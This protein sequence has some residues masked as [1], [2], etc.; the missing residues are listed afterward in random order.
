MIIGVTGATGF[1]GRAVLRHAHERGHEVIAFTRKPDR[2]VDRAMETRFFSTDAPPNL[3]GCEAVVH[4]AGEPIAG[5]WTPA[6]R[7]RIME[8]RVQGTRRVAEAIAAM[9]NKPEVLVS[10]SAVGFYADGGES[11][12]TESAREGR[13]FLAETTARWEHEAAQA[14]TARVGRL[15]TSIV[16]GRRG[17]ALGAMLP[18]FRAGLGAIMGSGRQW[19]PWIHLE[20]HAR[21]VLFAIEDMSVSGPL[22]AAAPWPIRQAGF[23]KELGRT[24]HRPVFLHAPAFALR[25]ILRGLAD[26]LLESKRVLPAAATE[27]GFGFKFPE[28]EP[29]LCDLIG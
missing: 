3:S 22:N 1:I 13:G 26:E 14:N 19:M 4:L 2:A 8:S 23:A 12:L 20:D 11:E 21:L 18:A 28:L 25:L 29:A 10:A 24:L 16:L 7:R 27:H 15:R 5:L 17:G 6:K 9:Q